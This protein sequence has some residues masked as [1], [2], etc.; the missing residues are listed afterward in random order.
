M[1]AATVL[2]LCQNQ[3]LKLNQMESKKTIAAQLFEKLI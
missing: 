1:C 3:S 2:L